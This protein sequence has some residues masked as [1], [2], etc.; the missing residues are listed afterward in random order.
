MGVYE[1][2]L[3]L[4]EMLSVAKLVTYSR[5]AQELG[6]SIETIRTDITALMCLYPIETVRGCNGGVKLAD[7][8]PSRHKALTD[9]QTAFLIKIRARF[10]KEELE[11]LDSIILQLAAQ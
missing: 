3:M 7:R 4:L 6:V 1:R 10:D 2:R 8:L 9:D 11:M 5:L